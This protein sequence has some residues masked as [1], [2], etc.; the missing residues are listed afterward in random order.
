MKLPEG[1]EEWPTLFGV[2][3]DVLVPRGDVRRLCSAAA[4]SP[5]DWL[6]VWAFASWSVPLVTSSVLGFL[7]GGGRL[8]VGL[9]PRG[10]SEGAC[11]R[12]S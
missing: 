5:E 7:R 4:R 6:A 1:R 11:R 10:P 3:E 12:L 2:T 8:T 9:L